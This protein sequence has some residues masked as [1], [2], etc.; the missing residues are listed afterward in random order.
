MPAAR[1]VR[2]SRAPPVA[3]GHRRHARQRPVRCAATLL[4]ILVGSSVLLGSA[5][6]LFRRLAAG[7]SD[8]RASEVRTLYGLP[9]R[10][11]SLGLVVTVLASSLTL[12]FPAI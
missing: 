6:P 8:V 4:V 2:A 1:G 10:L 12:V 5:W 3:G 7:T 9:L 11:I